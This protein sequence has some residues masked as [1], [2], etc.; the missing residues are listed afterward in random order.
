VPPRKVPRQIAEALA[1]CGLP[2]ECRMGKKHIKVYV[3]G[4]MV[5]V[6]SRDTTKAHDHGDCLNVIKAIRKAAT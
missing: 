1:E 2:S 4:R 6:V 3:N 5:G